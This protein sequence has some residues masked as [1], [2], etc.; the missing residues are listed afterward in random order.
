VGQGTRCSDNCQTSGDFCCELL[1]DLK[2]IPL[3]LCIREACSVFVTLAVLSGVRG[4]ARFLCDSR[5]ACFV[6]VVRCEP[7]SPHAIIQCSTDGN[8]VVQADNQ[9][10]AQIQQ[11]IT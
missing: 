10:I 6:P 4:V 8:P 1:S 3:I 2:P 11:F 7:V 5:A 9:Q